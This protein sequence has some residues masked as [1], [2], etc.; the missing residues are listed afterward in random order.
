M[1]TVLL[2]GIFFFLRSLYQSSVQFLTIITNKL[3]FKDFWTVFI[4]ILLK[5]HC[6]AE[7][8]HGVF[9]VALEQRADQPGNPERCEHHPVVGLPQKISHKERGEKRRKER[10]KEEKG[11]ESV[12]V[13]GGGGVESG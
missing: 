12:C 11:R 3:E 9:Q 1:F 6:T 7:T 2:G 10:K 13:G 4:L 5:V 8:V